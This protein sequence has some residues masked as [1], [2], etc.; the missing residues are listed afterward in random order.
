MNRL[1][2]AQLSV[3]DNVC[4]FT[5]IANKQDTPAHFTRVKLD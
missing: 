4:F 1:N 2:C 3:T 5:D